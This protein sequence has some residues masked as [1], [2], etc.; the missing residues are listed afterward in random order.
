MIDLTK[1]PTVRVVTEVEFVPLGCV[2]AICHALDMARNADGTTL[3]HKQMQNAAR[4][5]L[6]MQGIT[7]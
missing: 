3:S 2:V 1:R 5:A 6:V 4:A 7:D